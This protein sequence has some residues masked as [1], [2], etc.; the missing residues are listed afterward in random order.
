MKNLLPVVL[1]LVQDLT[2]HGV[3]VAP[4]PDD[5]VLLSTADWLSLPIM[6]QVI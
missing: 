2:A 6:Y 3:T 1:A 4:V 5:M